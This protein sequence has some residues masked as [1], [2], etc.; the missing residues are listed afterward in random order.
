MAKFF[1]ADGNEVEAFTQEELDAKIAEAK[2]VPLE[3]APEQKKD[4]ELPAWAQALI[5]Q[6][7]TLSGNQRSVF[8]GQIEQSLSADERSAFKAKYDSL[9]TGYDETPEGIRR[10]AEDAYLLTTGKK[11]DSSVNMANVV[12]AAGGPVVPAPP[13]K[14][15]DEGFKQV[16][17]LTDEDVNKYGPK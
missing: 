3:K 11:F 15:V 5:Q 12:A 10:R 2:A 14:E 16:F 13:R 8:V 9:T 1:D 4:D 6:V 17:G 7:Q